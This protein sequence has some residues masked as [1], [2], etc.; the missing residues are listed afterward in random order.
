M[1]VTQSVMFYLVIKVK[2]VSDIFGHSCEVI[3]IAAN[4]DECCQTMRHY[5]IE[6]M[7]RQKLV[8]YKYGLKSAIYSQYQMKGYLSFRLALSQQF[9]S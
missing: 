6:I 8:I 5:E 2:H 7:I 3:S 9:H 4:A 1:H